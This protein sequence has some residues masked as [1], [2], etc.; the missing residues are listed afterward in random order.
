VE[1]SS[2]RAANSSADRDDAAWLR[3]RGKLLFH[4]AFEREESGNGAK[5]I[6]NG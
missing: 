1:Q 3:A 6:G 5:A 4:N 2:E